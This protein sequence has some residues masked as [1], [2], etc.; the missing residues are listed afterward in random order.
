MVQLSRRL[1]LLRS[2]IAAAAAGA[3]ATS[4]GLVGELLPEGSEATAADS[5]TADAAASE[6]GTAEMSE[7]VVAHVKDLSTGEISL[8]SGTREVVLRDP[9]LAA[10]LVRAAN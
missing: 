6:A 5:A 8:F 2:S 1:F 7:P 4:P 10:R 3:L 9:Q